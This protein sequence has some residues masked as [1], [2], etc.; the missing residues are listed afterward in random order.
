MATRD[1]LREE[2][3]RRGL[4]LACQAKSPGDIA[5]EA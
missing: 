3:E 5:V 2:E 4:V 1:A